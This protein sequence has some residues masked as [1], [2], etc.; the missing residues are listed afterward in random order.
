MVEERFGVSGRQIET[1]ERWRRRSS[2]WLLGVALV[3]CGGEATPGGGGSG[4][5]AGSVIHSSGGAAASCSFTVTVVL[6]DLCIQDDSNGKIL[7]FSSVTGDYEFLDCR[8]GFFLSGKGTVTRQFG[9]DPCKVR[10]VHGGPDPKRFD[11]NITALVNI[12]TN[13]GD[14]TV[15]VFAQ[16]KTH[17][18]HDNNTTNNVCACL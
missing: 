3:G 16:G 13:V 1:R 9:S 2:S 15:Q 14:A 7:R 18:L 12:C 5:N 6:F 8:K 11:R 4:G 17:T 10:L